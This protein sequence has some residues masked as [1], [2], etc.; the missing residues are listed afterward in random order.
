MEVEGAGAEAARLDLP[1]GL[2]IF[3]PV[4]F[5]VEF[6]VLGAALK[7]VPSFEEDEESST[8][9]LVRAK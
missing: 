9:L 3:R 7:R 5:R 1:D 2:G 4:P 6:W 8:P